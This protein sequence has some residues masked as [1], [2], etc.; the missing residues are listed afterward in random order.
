MLD[1]AIPDEEARD[2]DDAPPTSVRVPSVPPVP[3][4]STADFDA[5]Y[6]ANFDRFIVQLHAYTADMAT[7]QDVV[8]EAFARALQRWSRVSTYDNP[9]AWVRRVAWNLATSNWRRIARF[10][11][12]MRKQSVERLVA[13]PSPDRVMLVRALATLPETQRRAVVLH[14][15]GDMSVNDIAA[16]ERVAPG[17]V[18]SWL[19]RGR[20]ALA[21]ALSDSKEEAPGREVHDG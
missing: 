10:N 11:T 8:Q 21:A 14:Y 6:L 13:E 1:M 12:F 18:K 7:A 20:A 3:A 16:Q 2:S 5:F 15:L 19:H 4:A 9:E 17:T